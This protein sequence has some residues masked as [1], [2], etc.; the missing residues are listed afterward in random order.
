MEQ[1]ADLVRQHADHDVHANL[2]P[3]PG[4]RAATGEHA[5]DHEEEHDLFRPRD[6]YT[7]E[8]AADDVDEIDRHAAHQ[9]NPRQRAGDR[10]QRP[11]AF[12]QRIHHG[13][14]YPTRPPAAYWLGA[15]RV[16]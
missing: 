13:R 3:I 11:H 14:T 1:I 4:D 5:A 2:P 10:Q 6:R 8:I 9:A 16:R 7:E 15:W 12:D